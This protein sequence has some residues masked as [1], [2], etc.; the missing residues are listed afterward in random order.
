MEEIDRVLLKLHH[1]ARNEVIKELIKKHKGN[2]SILKKLKI[3]LKEE[4]L[5]LNK[6]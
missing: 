4:K 2:F 5:I 3:M 6:S 1:K